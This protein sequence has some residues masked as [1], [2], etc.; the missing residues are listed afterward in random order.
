PVA[1]PAL[2]S[3]LISPQFTVFTKAENLKYLRHLWNLARDLEIDFDEAE[4]I[5]DDDFYWATR[6]DLEEYEYY[7]WN[8]IDDVI[9]SL[10]PSDV[11]QLANDQIK[12]AEE[13]IKEL[14]NGPQAPD[15]VAELKD[16]QGWI[17]FL[18]DEAGHAHWLAGD[19]HWIAE[20]P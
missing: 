5:N 16:L 14:E 12:K 11:A 20:S 7:L 10:P 9:D 1:A 18:D 2:P 8:E 19:F 17:D 13:G 4:N 15:N 6:D 3:N